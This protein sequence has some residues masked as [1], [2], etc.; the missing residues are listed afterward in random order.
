MP[1]PLIQRIRC[2]LRPLKHYSG[3]QQK[4]RG[5]EKRIRPALF[6]KIIVSR[7]R[8]LKD[9]VSEPERLMFQIIQFGLY[10]ILIDL[11]TG[12]LIQGQQH[13]PH[14]A[15]VNSKIG[16]PQTDQFIH[17]LLHKIQI[18]LFSCCLIRLRDSVIRDAAGPVPGHIHPHR[19]FHDPVH[20]LFHTI[21]VKFQ[22]SHLPV[23]PSS[24]VVCAFFLLL[25]PFSPLVLIPSTR[26]FWKKIKIITD[27][28]MDKEAM[29][30]IAP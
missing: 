20:S 3:P 10:D 2:Q 23:P 5:H 19:P 11:L 15:G 21:S 26:Y 28:R 9:M 4:E 16:K 13:V 29:A 12:V 27:G 6:R 18:L 7:H 25:Y 22:F 8:V 24:T 14:G 17:P 1:V 30:N